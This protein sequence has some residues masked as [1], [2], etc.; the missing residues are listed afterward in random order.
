MIKKLNIFAIIIVMTLLV[1][2][3]YWLATQITDYQPPEGYTLISVSEIDSLNNLKPD[4][5]VRDSLVFE[6]KIVYKDREIPTPVPV[7]PDI[8]FYSDS[9]INDTTHLIINDT[10]RG[11]LLSR[12]IEL[13][14]AIKYRTINIPYPKFIETTKFIE[15][16]NPWSL[17]GGVILSGTKNKFIPGIEMGYISK[18]NIKIGAQLS[19]DFNN[20]YIGVAIGK[21]FD[22]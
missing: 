12:N 11:S 9:L 7:T 15:R 2:F 16:P 3:G 18:K 13:K 5:V 8:N 14:R 1:G 20:K 22:F 4:T 17:Y 10:I 6:E 19:T 21:K